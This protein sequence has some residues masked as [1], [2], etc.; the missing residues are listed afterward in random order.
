MELKYNAKENCVESPANENS[1]LLPDCAVIAVRRELG[2][3]RRA[4]DRTDSM[5]SDRKLGNAN[6]TSVGTKRG[7]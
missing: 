7:R 3:L 2:D 6:E 5:E 1:A 4:C